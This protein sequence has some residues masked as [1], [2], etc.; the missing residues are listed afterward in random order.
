MRMALHFS[1]LPPLN[2]KP[3]FNHKKTLE[4]SKWSIFYEI[5]ASIPQN[6]QG[7]Q[8]LGKSKKGENDN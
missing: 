5:L 4:N 7:H 2:T 6:S 1:N 8:K 3:R